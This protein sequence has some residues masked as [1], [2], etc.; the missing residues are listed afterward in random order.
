[1]RIIEKIR[2]IEEQK[3]SRLWERMPKE[4]KREEEASLE[5]K[6]GKLSPEG[7]IEDRFFSLKRNR[8]LCYRKL[9][10]KNKFKAALDLRWTYLEIGQTSYNSAYFLQGY[11]YQIIFKKENKCTEIFLKSNE[12]EIEEIRKNFG[13]A[14][15]VF[16]DFHDEFI[17]IKQI[18]DSSY[19]K[20]SYLFLLLI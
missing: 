14:G 7:I 9:G 19:G 11:N 6:A 16:E 20:V 12:E 3:P 1:M 10:E 13:N 15:A 8:F 4:L 2:S 18:S 5:F 17:P